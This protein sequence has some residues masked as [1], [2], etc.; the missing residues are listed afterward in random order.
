MK[1]LAR[2]EFFSERNFIN[3]E[4]WREEI[5]AWKILPGKDFWR[6]EI[7]A[8]KILARKEFWRKEIFAWKNFCRYGICVC[9]GGMGGIWWIGS[10]S[11]PCPLR[12]IDFVVSENCLKLAGVDF[13]GCNKKIVTVLAS[14]PYENSCSIL[15]EKIENW[16][17]YSNVKNPVHFFL[18]KNAVFRGQN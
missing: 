17:S 16:K 7:L 8:W 1:N 13:D 6:E 9:G 15:I 4:F 14:F 10:S 3:K 2:K 18:L 11:N 12:G 5:F